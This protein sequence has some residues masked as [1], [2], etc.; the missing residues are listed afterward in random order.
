M[1]NKVNV[2]TSSTPSLLDRSKATQELWLTVLPECSPPELRQFI[3][4]CDR[5]SNDVI[6]R[7]VMRMARKFKF[8]PIPEP[9]QAHKYFTGL[10]LKFQQD[11]A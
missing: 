8:N 7:A 6:D 1:T 9:E 2:T 3:R 11:E 4:W 10:L 5:F